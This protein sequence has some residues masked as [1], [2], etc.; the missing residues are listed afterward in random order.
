MGLHLKKCTNKSK[1]VAKVTNLP[2]IA[3]DS[4]LSIRC[5]DN[6]PGIHSARVLM[7]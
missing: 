6:F 4:G 1:A 2:T 5:L 3:D 7:S